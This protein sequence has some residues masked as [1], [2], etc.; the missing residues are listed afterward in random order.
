MAVIKNYSD[1]ELLEMIQEVRHRD[2]AIRFIYRNYFEALSIYVQQ[3]RGSSQDAEDIF[4]E[5]IVAFIGAVQQQKFR[6]ESAVKTFLYS[7]NKHIWLNELKRRGRA[8][9]RET[10]YDRIQE[11]DQAD[12]TPQIIRKETTALIKSVMDTLGETCKKILL[13]FYYEN[14]SMKEILDSTDFENEQVLRN[15][16][17]KCLKKLEQ[18]VTNDPVLARSLKEALQYGE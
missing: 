1:A 10:V 15:K 16:K 18:S 5:T 4:Q 7:I 6:G 9:T 17:H 2:D 3:N 8:Q 12:F 11:T 14:R 13:A